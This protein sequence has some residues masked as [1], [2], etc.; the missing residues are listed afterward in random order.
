MPRK[1]PLPKLYWVETDDHAEDWFVV[2]RTAREACRFHEV[3]EG[4]DRGDARS[5]LVT[6][7]AEDAEEG[8]PRLEALTEY[9]LNVL[10][11]EQPRVVEYQGR[12]FGEGGLEYTMLYNTDNIFEV[13][14]QGRPNGTTRREIQ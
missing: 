8:W 11:C 9:G 3:Q 5:T 7:L 4:Y 13:D 1:K 6:T 2:A 14:G 12:R 10:R